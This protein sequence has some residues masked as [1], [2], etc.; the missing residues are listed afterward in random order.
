MI[1]LQAY[2]VFD[3]PGSYIDVEVNHAIV[4]EDRSF[5]TTERLDDLLQHSLTWYIVLGR[6]EGGDRVRQPSRCKN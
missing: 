1:G 4:H 6:M 5:P 3:R 2:L